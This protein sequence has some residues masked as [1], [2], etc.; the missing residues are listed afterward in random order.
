MASC[1][2]SAVTDVRQSTTVPNVSNTSAFTDPA[3]DVDGRP[4]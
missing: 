2:T 1:A 4:V 3:T